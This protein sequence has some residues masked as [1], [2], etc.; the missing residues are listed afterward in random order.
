MRYIYPWPLWLGYVP[1]SC[2]FVVAASCWPFKPQL[3][4]ALAWP[5]GSWFPWLIVQVRS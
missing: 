2:G 4:L 5:P 1:V 3:Q